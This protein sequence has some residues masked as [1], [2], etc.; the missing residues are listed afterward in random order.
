MMPI[1]EDAMMPV[2]EGV[3]ETLQRSGPC[4]SSSPWIGCGGTDGWCFVHS[5]TRPIR[6]HSTRSL[7]TPVH[8]QASWNQV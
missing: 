8:Q 2:E 6:S 3:V 4:C 1:E 7:W 5:A